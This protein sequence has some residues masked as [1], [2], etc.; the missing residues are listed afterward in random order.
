MEN[1][2]ESRTLMKPS[3]YKIYLHSRREFGSVKPEKG[4]QQGFSLSF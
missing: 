4:R 1:I 2:Q 3:M